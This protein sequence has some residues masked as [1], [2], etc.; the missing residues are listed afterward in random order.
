[1]GFDPLPTSTTAYV[2]LGSNLGNREDHLLGALAALRE[3]EGV[4]DVT[5]SRIYETD[6][7]DCPEP[8]PYLNAVA[9]VR[10]HLDVNAFFERLMA[11]EQDFARKRSYRNAPRTLDLDLL[12]FGNLHLEREDLTVP[13]P[14]LQ[15]RLFVCVPFVDVA[16]DWVHPKLQLALSEILQQLRLGDPDLA[17]PVVQ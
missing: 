16:P 7:V 1:M 6:A 8:F 3:T 17:E 14:R 5:A 12:A 9:A 15:E 2:G 13:H 4:E 11:I 10:T